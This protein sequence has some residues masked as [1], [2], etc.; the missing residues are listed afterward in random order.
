MSMILAYAESS[1]SSASLE[2]ILGGAA[3]IAV[4][5]LLA[6]ILVLLARSRRHRQADIITLAMIVWSILTAGSLMWEGQA[7]VNWTQEYNSRVMSGYYDPANTS[8]APKMPWVLWGG[9]A[10]AY[11]ALLAWTVSQKNADADGR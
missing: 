6:F 9:L 7:Q 8:D 5:A 2:L 3:I 10:V 1:D 4:T 11:V